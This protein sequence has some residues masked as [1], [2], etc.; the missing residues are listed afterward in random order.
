MK[1]VSRKRKSE[2]AE[3]HNAFTDVLE[4]ESFLG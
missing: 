4:N 2:D 3:R 1:A